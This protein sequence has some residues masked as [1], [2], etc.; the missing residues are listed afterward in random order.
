MDKSEIFLVGQYNDFEINRHFYT[1]QASR[2]E[3]VGILV[4]LSDMIE[5]H[6]YRFSGIETQ[7]I[8]AIVQVQ[9][10]LNGVVAFLRSVKRDMLLDMAPRNKETGEPKKTMVPIVENYLLRQALLRAGVP[11]K[12]QAHTTLQ[13]QS[14]GLEDQIIFVGNC[15]GWF[16]VKK[17]T[18][19]D[20]TADW[21][22]AGL[23]SSINNTIMN[24]VWEWTEPKGTPGIGGRKSLGK[25]ADALGA[26][27]EPDP[28]A[29]CKTCE[30]FG[31]KPY[32]SPEMLTDEYPD[33]KP[34]KTKGRK[35]KIG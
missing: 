13:P 22:V 12:P 18:I 29:V 20:K 34:P 19:E 31:Y 9:P 4:Q 16:S 23:L 10:G 5:P 21:E 15:E 17:L 2:P 26:L 30:N 33:I 7:R 35:R 28:Y 1:D 8:D 25:L 6:I 24:R 32:G 11:F 3:L 27:T 14:D